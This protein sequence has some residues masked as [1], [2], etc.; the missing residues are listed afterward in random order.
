MIDFVGTPPFLRI[1][2]LVAMESM[3]LRLA[4]ISVFLEDKICLHSGG[5]NEQF[6]THE[7][8]SWCAR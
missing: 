4:R 7:R 3:H 5:P 1:T 2:L 8:L 6:G